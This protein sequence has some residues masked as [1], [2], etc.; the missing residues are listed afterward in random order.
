MADS[1]RDAL[2]GVAGIIECTYAHDE[3][4]RTNEPSNFS[5]ADIVEALCGIEEE[6]FDGLRIL[7]TQCPVVRDLPR[8]TLEA[9]VLV[10]LSKFD[11]TDRGVSWDH[12]D[13][14][15]C[16]YCMLEA[17]GLLG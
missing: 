14:A 17:Q 5:G 8:A 16:A 7:D 1:I 13:V 2:R 12:Q 9:I 3:N 10:L 6:V 4:G 11:C 15:N